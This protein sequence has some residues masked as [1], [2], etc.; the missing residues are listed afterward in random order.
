[1][2]TERSAALQT[3][4]RSVIVCLVTE[5]F[6]IECNTNV[7]RR[8]AYA[9]DH[10]YTE[11][12]QTFNFE[13]DLSRKIMLFHEFAIFSPVGAIT[14]PGQAYSHAGFH[15]FLRPNLQIDVHAAVGLNAAAADMVG[16]SGLSAK[17]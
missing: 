17:W 7:N 3:A 2:E 5:R 15:F 16:G 8:F 13:Y 10:F 9:A 12:L 6:E 11:Y 14:V 1:M 4:L